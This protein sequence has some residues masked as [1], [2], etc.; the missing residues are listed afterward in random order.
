M[1]FGTFSVTE[2]NSRPKPVKNIPAQPIAPAPEDSLMRQ[3]GSGARTQRMKIRLIGR[4]MALIRDF[5]CSMERNMSEALQAEGLSFYTWDHDTMMGM[6]HR[7][8]QLE[9]FFWENQQRRVCPAIGDR[10]AVY[11]FCISYA[12]NQ[13]QV[14]ELAIHC[15]AG[16]AAAAADGAD[17]VWLLADG[18]LYQNPADP[19]TAG[20]AGALSRAVQSGSAPV[21]LIL[22][23]IE[24][25]G[26]YPASGIEKDL[27]SAAIK[28]ILDAAREAMS[29]AVGED[30]SAAML[31]VQLYGGLEFD[32]LDEQG[33]IV[34]RRC[35]SGYFQSYLPQ[36]CHTPLI[37]T[38]RAVS[39]NRDSVLLPSSSGMT[40]EK[41]LIHHCASKLG[42]AAWKPDTLGGEAK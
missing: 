3:S 14:L 30:S 1:P 33:S 37:H 42:D 9:M 31:P 20:L 41:A 34:L 10:E 6:V 12:G 35:Q 19:F 16:N 18:A 29:G 38:L 36:R 13:Q 22:S 15:A 5:L 21:C 27:P 26:H 24:G 8:K 7:K 4:N 11:H 2:I 17:A 32:C 28:Q 40:L 23:Q 39:H 25:V